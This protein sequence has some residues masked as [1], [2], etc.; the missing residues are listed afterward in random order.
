MGGDNRMGRPLLVV[1]DRNHTCLRDS[2]H[3][4]DN[5]NGLSFSF[6]FDGR[7]ALESVFALVIPT[8]I[9]RPHL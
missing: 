1:S 2:F 7:G 3:N 5:G 6:S 4:V 8:F 9:P